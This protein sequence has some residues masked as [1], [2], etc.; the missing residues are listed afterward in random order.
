MSLSPSC[1][2]V[3]CLKLHFLAPTL[4]H[5]ESVLSTLLKS[6]LA[7]SLLHIGRTPESMG[8]ETVQ[9]ISEGGAAAAVRSGSTLEFIE[10]K[11]RETA[12]S[13]TM[14]V[15]VRGVD[16]GVEVNTMSVTGRTA[17][18]MSSE[19]VWSKSVGRGGVRFGEPGGVEE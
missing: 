5:V 1:L 11:T 17:G 9:S 8:E 3:Q 15:T 14:S 7:V 6:V 12:E 18:D 2:L 10:S 4:N 19:D 13:G 16:S